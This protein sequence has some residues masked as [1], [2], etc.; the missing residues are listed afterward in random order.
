MRESDSD[1]IKMWVHDVHLYPWVGKV[2][3]GLEDEAVRLGFF[4]GGG[5][6]F[7]LANHQLEHT[8]CYSVKKVKAKLVS[9]LSTIEISVLFHGTPWVEYQHIPI[10]SLCLAEDSHD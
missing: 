5:R 7:N 3:P 4:W 6:L 9:L 2:P 8:S 10:F 1:G